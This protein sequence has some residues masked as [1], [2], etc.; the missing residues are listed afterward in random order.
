MGKEGWEAAWWQNIEALI[1]PC[2]RCLPPVC[3]RLVAVRACAE[4]ACALCGVCGRV[5]VCGEGVDRDVGAACE[6]EGVGLD[7]LCATL[8]TGHGH[9]HEGWWVTRPLTFGG[10]LVLWAGLVLLGLIEYS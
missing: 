9:G 2:P 3:E 8:A 5:C 6:A 1:P 10:G 4:N 7:W